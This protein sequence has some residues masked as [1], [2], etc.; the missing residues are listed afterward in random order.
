MNEEDKR[1][2]LSLCKALNAINA[3]YIDTKSIVT[4]YWVRYKCRFG[5]PRYNK[6]L[7]CPPDSPNVDETR[8]M[9]SEFSLGLLIHF[10]SLAE[11]TKAIVKIE[12]EIFLKNYY[13]VISFGG[14]PC[15]LCKTCEK[16]VCKFPKLARPSMEGC[17]IDV[18]ATVMNNNFPIHVLTSKEENQ[19]AYG[20]VLIE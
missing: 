14:G 1:Y 3:N 9:I 12:R 2:F 4:G 16:T 6:S 19:N 11:V 8:K 13:K 10:K 15:K 17:G 5:C 20:L 7:C 18:Y